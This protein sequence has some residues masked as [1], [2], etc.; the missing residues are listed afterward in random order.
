MR[1]IVINTSSGDG[2]YGG[3]SL[4]HRAWL[5]LRELGQHEALAEPD[6]AA[7]WPEAASPREPSL[8]RCGVLIPRDDN[9]LVQVVQELGEA[10]NGHCAE[11]RVVAIP[12]DADWEIETVGGVEHISEKHRSWT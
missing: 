4:S 3:F 2:Q 11:L 5:R 1:Y 9:K 7:Y 6:A 12:D 8:N 10:A